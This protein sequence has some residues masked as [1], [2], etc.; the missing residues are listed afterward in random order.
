MS[1]VKDFITYDEV[2]A[3]RDRRL[4]DN[5]GLLSFTIFS[6]H[7]H[8]LRWLKWDGLIGRY[9]IDYCTSIDKWHTHKCQSLGEA[10]TF[11]NLMGR[12]KGRE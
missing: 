8:G 12:D 6:S 7:S 1:R 11:Y 2:I 3:E 10:M 5:D 4:K 9:S